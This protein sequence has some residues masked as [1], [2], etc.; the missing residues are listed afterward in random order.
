M[1]G[2]R[3][4]GSNQGQSFACFAIQKLPSR[5]NQTIACFGAVASHRV[6]STIL[7]PAGLVA[8]R[9]LGVGPLRRTTDLARN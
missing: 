9:T 5:A 1:R 8:N 7:T 2:G 6:R 4:V 3:L